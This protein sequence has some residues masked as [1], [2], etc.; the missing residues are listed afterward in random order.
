[1]V[2]VGGDCHPNGM[3]DS[4]SGTSSGKTN[5]AFDLNDVQSYNPVYGA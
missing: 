2:I 1:L 5:L 3:A 4:L